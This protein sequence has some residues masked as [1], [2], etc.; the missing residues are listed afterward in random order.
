MLAA[1]WPSAAQIWRVKAATEVLPLVPVTA[2]M[3]VGLARIEAR[4]RE[5]QRAPHVGGAHEGDVVR[6]ASS[7]ARS[8][9]TAT[10]PAASACG[11]KRQAVRLGARHRD[12]QVAGLHL[13]AVGRDAGDVDAPRSAASNWPSGPM[14]SRRAS[15]SRV[16]A[17]DSAAIL[18]SAQRRK[19]DR[20]RRCRADSSGLRAAC[21]LARISWSAGGRS[22]RGS[23][24]SIGAMRAMTLPAVGAAFQPEVAKPCVSGQALRLVEQ[25][26]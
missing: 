19:R 7:G 18:R 13:A 8:A 16:P 26:Q 15:S 5:R 10:A 6:A 23:S 25:D 11:T 17:T 22:R 9:M 1:S 24:P 4:R 20:C 12:E 14:R 3:V 21:S 2:A